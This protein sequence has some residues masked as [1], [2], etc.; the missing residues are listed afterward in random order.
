MRE[1]RAGLCND[2]WRTSPPSGSLFAV[3]SAKK[4]S[5]KI[6]YSKASPKRSSVP[7]L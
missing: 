3:E 5:W 7:I 4:L 2:S 1:E 6:S